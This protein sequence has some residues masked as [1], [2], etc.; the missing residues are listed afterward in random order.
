MRLLVA[1][2]VLLACAV[3]RVG[4]APAQFRCNWWHGA[5]PTG[6]V[7]PEGAGA[8]TLQG[9][10]RM[11]LGQCEDVLCDARTWAWVS[12]E[13]RWGLGLRAGGPSPDDYHDLLPQ[14]E[15]EPGWEVVWV[16]G[17]CRAWY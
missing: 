1:V 5:C 7:V 12:A 15:P 3:V 8:T 10:I 14:L 17:S 2:L 9:H 4:N 16:P 6:R 13:V 11:H